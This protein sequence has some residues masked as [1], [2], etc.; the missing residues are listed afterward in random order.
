YPGSDTVPLRVLTGHLDRQG[1]EA[2]S[3]L[4]LDLYP[5]GRLADCRYQPGEDLT[6]AA[7]YFDASGYE[8]LPV[9]LCP[10]TV[11]RGG[12]RGRVFYSDYAARGAARRSYDS[13]LDRALRRLPSFRQLPPFRARRRRNPPCLTKVPLIRWQ[14]RSRYLTIHWIA[15]QRVA[16]ES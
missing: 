3:C 10:G 13:L 12:V 2:F 6:A 8:R 4:L 9:D 11:V 7:P 5:A 15:P 14:S 1:F 16:P